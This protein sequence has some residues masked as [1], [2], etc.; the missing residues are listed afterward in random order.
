MKR[1]LLIG[2]GAAMMLA[3][4]ILPAHAATSTGFVA[5]GGSGT[6]PSAFGAL[7]GDRLRVEI[8]ARALPNGTAV[9]RFHLLHQDKDG[10][11]AAELSGPI[12]CL[13]IE[14]EQA[15]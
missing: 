15:R 1:V 10:R 14:G 11:L 2:V 12:G 13:A 6:L 9:G 8:T 5:G 4:A 3:A 7:A